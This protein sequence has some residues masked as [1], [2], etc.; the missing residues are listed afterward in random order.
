VQEKHRLASS[1]ASAIH[2]DIKRGKTTLNEVIQSQ[3]IDFPTVL[4]V[5]ELMLGDKRQDFLVALANLHDT[6][7]QWFID[8]FSIGAP[9]ALFS[10]KGVRFSQFRALKEQQLLQLRNEL[11]GVWQIDDSDVAAR[12]R[13]ERYLRSWLAFPVVPDNNDAVISALQKRAGILDAPYVPISP[14]LELGRLIVDPRNL[15]AQLAQGV[16]EHHERMKVCANPECVI[17]YFLAKR[18]TQKYCEEGICVNYAA[19]QYKRDYWR[20]TFGAGSPKPKNKTTKKGT[21]HGKNKAN[22]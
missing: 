13:I 2:R 4:T 16:L 12:T 8:K 15:A 10:L 3:T 22:R 5:V 17:P 9:L 14:S 7:Y 1:R 18:R 6:G 20:K 21:K 19:R 11:R